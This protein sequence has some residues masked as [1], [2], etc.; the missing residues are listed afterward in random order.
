MLWCLRSCLVVG[1]AGRA[2]EKGSAA[3]LS[4]EATVHDEESKK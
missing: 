4:F 3:H 2:G 1:R